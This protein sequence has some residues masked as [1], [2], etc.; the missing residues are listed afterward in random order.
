MGIGMISGGIDWLDVLPPVRSLGTMYVLYMFIYILVVYF[1]L[2]HVLTG[3]FVNA[4]THAVALNREI[5]IDVA[6][7]TKNTITQELI[8]LFLEAGKEG[9][10]SVPWSEFQNRLCDERI[11]AYFMSL[12]LD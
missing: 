3:I 4:S 1:G 11:R 12:D 9:E 2:T 8:T 5:A 10:D 7:A 6:I